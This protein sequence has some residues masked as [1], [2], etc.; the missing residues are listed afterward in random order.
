MFMVSNLK[1][2]AGKFGDTVKLRIPDVDRARR[3]PRNLLAAILEI[4][5]EEFYQLGT[6]QGRLSQLYARNQFTICEEKF[7]LLDD[8]SDLAISLRECVRKTSLSGGQGYQRCL[9]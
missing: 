2:P 8:V 1:F 5:N 9:C 3:D 6:K 4:Q 7:I